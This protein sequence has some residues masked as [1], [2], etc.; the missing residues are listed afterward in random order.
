LARGLVSEVVSLATIV[1]AVI[2]AV[3]FSNTLAAY[4]TN[5]EVVQ[6]AVSQTSS[7]IGVSTA[8][9]VSY[10]AIGVSFFVLFSSTMIVGAIV[11]MLLSIAVQTG[12]LGFG[13]RLLGGVFGAIRGFIINLVLIFLIQLTPMSSQAWWQHSQLVS[14]FQ[15]AVVGLG[16]LVSPV[17]S[18]LKSRFG[19]TIEDVTSQIQGAAKSL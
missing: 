6:T 11:R 4:F 9:P 2:I 14:M 19:Q 8:K 17:L 7:A 13:N 10:M 12:L 15:P 3:L 1:A 5:T 16:N 18:D